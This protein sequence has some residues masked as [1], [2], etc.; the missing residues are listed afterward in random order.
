MMKNK[1]FQVLILL[2]ELDFQ[3]HLCFVPDIQMPYKAISGSS[4]E[5]TLVTKT[6][7]CNDVMSSIKDCALSCF[8]RSQSRFGCSG[9]YTNGNSCKLCCINQ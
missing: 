1:I 5:I 3:R 6:L 7:I 9:F 8:N 4:P 2:V